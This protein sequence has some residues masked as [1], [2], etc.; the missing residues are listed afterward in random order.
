[1]SNVDLSKSPYY[2]DYDPSKGYTQ[3]LSVPGRVAQARDLTQAQSIMKDIIKSIGDSIMKDGDIVDGCQVSVALDKKSVTVSAGRVYIGGVVYPVEEQKVSIEGTGTE[4]IGVLL[5]ESIVT[6]VQ[7]PTL[8]D[9]ALG[10]DNYNKAGSNRLK[11]V[12]KVVV[13]NSAASPLSTLVEGDLQLETYSPE[14][15]TLT[16]TL[17]RRTFDESGSYIV[18][19]MSVKMEDDP[20]DADHYVAVIEAGKAYVLGYELGIPVARRIRVPRSTA[21]DLV[22]ASNYVYTPGTSIY[23]LDTDLYVKDIYSVTGTVQYTQTNMSITTGSDR[24]LLDKGSVIDILKVYVGTK[25]YVKGTDYTLVRDGSRYYL[26]WS[27][28]DFPAP[29]VAFTTEYTYSKT[30]DSTEYSLVVSNGSHCIQWTNPGLPAA[31]PINN[32]NFTVKYNQYLARKDVVY[33]DQ[34]GVIGVQQGIPAEYG[35]EVAPESPINTLSL[36]II[37]SPPNGSTASNYAAQRIS[38]SNIG[39]TR[40]TMQDIQYLLNRVRTLEYD[41]AVVSLEN[42][43][44]SEFTN[45]EKKGIITDPFVDLSRSDLTYNLKTDGITLVDPNQ[46][47]FATAIDFEANI[48]YLPVVDSIVDT[49]YNASMTTASIRDNRLAMLGKVSTKIVLD[50]PHA[51]KSFLVNPYSMYPGTPAIT[52]DPFVDT[53]IDTSIIEVPVSLTTS[54]IVSTTSQTVRNRV[55]I[56]RVFRDYTETSSSVSATEVGATTETFTRDSVI[57]ETAVEYIRQR[58]INVYGEDFPSDLDNIKCYF[59]DKLVSLTPLDGTEAGTEDGSVKSNGSGAFS[60]KFTIPTGVRTGTRE[61]KLQSDIKI[62]GWLTHAV[63]TYQANGIKR[64][65]QR[66]VTTLTTVLLARQE[67]IYETTY[68]DPVGQSFVLDTDTLLSGVDVYFEAKPASRAPIILEIRGVTNGVIN[69]IVYAHKSLQ[70]TEVSVSP[71]SSVPTRF[72]LDSP[73]YCEKNTQYAFVLKSN[74]DEYRLWVAD[75]GEDDVLT[76]ETILKNV[77]LSGLM[78][79]SSN[80]AAWSI[81]QTSDIKFRLLADTCATEAVL[82]FQPITGIDW[83]SI[84]VTADQVIPVGTSVKWEYSTDG[85]NYKD[86]TPY[87]LLRMNA[88]IQKLYLKATLSR[89]ESTALSPIIALDTVSVIGSKFKTSGD[90][91]MKNITNLDPYDEVQVVV[92]T[93]VP[94]GTTLN[95]YASRDDGATWDLLTLDP[96]RTISRNYGW[97]EYTYSKDYTNTTTQCRLRVHMDSINTYT[98][99]A[100]RRYRGIMTKKV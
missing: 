29:G 46:P 63:T 50:Q 91:I 55:V 10:Y 90:Y 100:I 76:K 88:V 65:I 72:N 96:D 5:E 59:D 95:F 48:A 52:I 17:A 33:I 14:Y 28:I 98:S 53:W 41:N 69:N 51:S 47:I 2:D 31:H 83:T 15:D 57:S 11:G 80:N 23:E 84:R 22:E 97:T 61:V 78:Y 36:A 25:V 58:D 71:D 34:Y 12:V 8:R 81:H 30:F 60:C 13:N 21:Y 92:E 37:M 19:G 24:C 93:Y 42:D 99:P 79:S 73:V 35:F 1:M 44:R 9:P 38:V 45:N 94:A 49:K 18:K 20:T 54:T 75:M 4:V 68:V 74:S 70:A 26:Q 87:D 39:L 56:H 86:F 66:T 32:S 6:E 82:Y 67:T 77:Y 85:T 64:V 89:T 7:D 3:V 40:F 27:N 62:D 16:Q 43:A